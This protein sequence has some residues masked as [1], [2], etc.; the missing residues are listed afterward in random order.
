MAW[1]SRL[2]PTSAK[3]RNS[4]LA[5]DIPNLVLISSYH[6]GTVA[7]KAFWWLAPFPPCDMFPYD[8]SIKSVRRVASPTVIGDSSYT[9][10][11]NA[12]S[13]RTSTF[14][15]MA[16]G[17]AFLFLNLLHAELKKLP[18]YSFTKKT[19]NSSRKMCVRIRIKFFFRVCRMHYGQYCEHHPLIP[20]GEVI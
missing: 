18:E 9:T 17:K 19:W 7:P 4:N 5:F 10:L 13:G 14:C 6:W 11:H 16:F 3:N 1:V 12:L 20:C 15:V 8:V 2:I